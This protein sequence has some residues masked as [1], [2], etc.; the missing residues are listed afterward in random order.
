MNK[1]TTTITYLCFYS[2]NNLIISITISRIQTYSNNNDY[3]VSRRWL[4]QLYNFTGPNFTEFFVLV[5][6]QIFRYQRRR[7]ISWMQYM[8]KL[9]QLIWIKWPSFRISFGKL[10]WLILSRDSRQN[11]QRQQLLFN[12]VVY[13]CLQTMAQTIYPRFIKDYQDYQRLSKLLS[14]TNY[15][16]NMNLCHQFLKYFMLK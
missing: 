2:F 9:I 3:L 12:F 13:S 1:T 6:F 16:F 5:L 7:L 15:T 14:P 4:K 11:F 8:I 10:F